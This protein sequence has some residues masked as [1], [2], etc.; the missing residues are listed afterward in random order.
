MPHY[1]SR[2]L[3]KPLKNSMEWSPI[4]S[5]IGGRQ[6]GK[7]T[8]LKKLSKEYV[9]FDDPRLEDRFSRSGE[10]ILDT[11]NKPF[12]LDEIQK[13]PPAFDLIKLVVDR[14]RRPAQFLI[15]GS[16]RFPSK[17]HIRESLAGRS[18]TWELL[19]LTTSETLERPFPDW[20][21]SFHGRDN[22][23]ALLKRFKGRSRV[24]VPQIQYYLKRG[25]LPGICFLRDEAQRLSAIENYLDTLLG[26]D[27]LFLINTKSKIAQLLQLLQILAQQQGLPLN[28]SNAARLLNL[29]VPTVSRTLSA[30]E[31]LFLIRPHGRGWYFEDQG[32]ASYLLRG[33]MLGPR[34]EIQR[35]VWS[36][37]RAQTLYRKDYGATLTEYSTR[38]GAYVPFIVETSKGIRLAITISDGDTLTEKN[39]KSLYS[40]KKKFP[41]A[42]LIHL[43]QGESFHVHKD[44]L[45]MPA[46]AVG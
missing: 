10:F 30:L 41:G 22:P 24:S 14:N 17:K 15:S 34:R 42:R 18:I 35:W 11:A 2:F 4:V 37:L 27:I 33:Q 38:G 40:Y 3:E 23:T 44:I 9:S 43:H 6:T 20:I 7:T 28:L 13:F 16:I 31:A 46:G 25:G 8:L 32:I 12:F 1:R 26:R 21:G 36:E 45:S 39:L 5:L 29:S 19:P